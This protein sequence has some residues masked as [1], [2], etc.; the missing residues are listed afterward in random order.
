MGKF[1]KNKKKLTV[2]VPC[3]N[4]EETI[5]DFFKEMENIHPKIQLDFEYLFINDGSKDKTLRILRKLK[6]KYPEMVYYISFS[7]N[8]GKEAAIFAGLKYSSGD[9]VTLMD[10]D[11]QDP[12]E[13]L[14][15]MYEK[16]Q[17]PEIDCV[18]ARRSNREGEPWLLSLASRSFYKIMNSISETPV[19]DGVRDFRL[20]TR[21]MVNAILEIGEYNRFSKGIFSWVGFETEYVA[22]ENRERIAGET[23]WSFWSKVRYATSG[24]VNFSEAP[25]L[26][27]TYTGIFFV[28]GAI[29]SV[30]I[31]IVRQLAFDKS[32]PG[33]TSMIVIMLFC[34]GIVMLALGII[35]K[36]ISN[37]FL[38]SKQRPIFVIK[39]KK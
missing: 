31:L 8:F 7:R 2:I 36:Y 17:N 33:W 21:Q 38:E 4:E 29:F 20:M 39:E 11:L 12:P 30:I 23:K 14:V 15:E 27:V 35:G 22:Y 19:V 9:Y 3:Y 1:E 24:F 25:L 6:E 28:L 34:F 18:A 13:L 10:A 26:L 32:A 37:I 16:I 5:L